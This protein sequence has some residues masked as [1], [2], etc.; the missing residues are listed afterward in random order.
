[1]RRA[2]GWTALLAVI[3]TVVVVAAGSAPA[4]ARTTFTRGFDISWPQCRGISAR[5]VP[6]QP[7]EFVILGL[8]DGSGHTLNPCLGSQV[9]WARANQVKVGAY[10]V[11]SYP[12]RAQLRAQGSHCGDL[13]CRLRGDGAL[14]ARDALATMRVNHLNAPMVWVDVEFRHFQ[15]W[16]SHRLRNRYVLEG[17][18][19]ALRH[20]HKRFG[21]YSTSYMWEH[22]TGGYRL[23]VPNWL[24]SGNGRPASAKRMCSA[25]ATG[26]RTWLVQYTRTLDEDL[27][28]PVL[29]P[30]RGHHS[31]L[32]KYRNTVVKL[33]SHGQAVRLVQRV[34]HL[35]VNG[36][37]GLF[38]RLSVRQWQHKKHLPVT[39]TV[40]R[41]DWRAMG[42]FR[43]HG[44]HGFWLSR[45]VTR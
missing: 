44:G 43:R 40:R 31:R 10:L 33:W 14:Q 42:A 27:T 21:V 12:T 16:S 7:P 1:M 4:T 32:W 17:V 15:S 29:D 30:V 24:P 34:L 26:G 6:S 36:T 2:T 45:I 11:P 8:T 37:F 5:H 20:A 39:G 18:V 28:C 25:T 38:T 13:A 41:R 3:S 35:A 9:A 22:I 19:R 23:D